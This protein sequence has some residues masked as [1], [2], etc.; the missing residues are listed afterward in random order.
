VRLPLFTLFSTC[1]GFVLRISH[2]IDNKSLSRSRVHHVHHE[3]NCVAAPLSTAVSAVL[4]SLRA[5]IE[6]S[7][8]V[9]EIPLPQY[10]TLTRD[11]RNAC[12]LFAAATYSK[13]NQEMTKCYNGK[14]RE[15]CYVWLPLI[16]ACCLDQS[17]FWE[18]I[19]SSDGGMVFGSY[20][21]TTYPRSGGSF[22]RVVDAGWVSFQEATRSVSR[23]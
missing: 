14:S 1:S 22:R 19:T 18:P 17:G 3:N 15:R 23:F 16:F 11:L 7:G 13:L 20:K 9:R 21:P 10:Y 12:P 6:N 2:N 5:S 8:R 4:M